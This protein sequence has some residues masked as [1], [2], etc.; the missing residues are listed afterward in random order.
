MIG[1]LEPFSHSLLCGWVS[2]E[3]WLHYVIAGGTL[4]RFIGNP[5]KEILPHKKIGT[6]IWN[7]VEAHGISGF[8]FW[9]IVLVIVTILNWQ[10]GTF[11][12]IK[13]YKGWRKFWE[14]A[15]WVI[16]IP[17]DPLFTIVGIIHQFQFFL[18][19]HF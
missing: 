10:G 11:K 4:R 17:L 8:L 7:F 19:G 3:Q 15:F 16:T 9:G 14:T 12:R 5:A 2:F 18:E 13:K 1:H 6:V